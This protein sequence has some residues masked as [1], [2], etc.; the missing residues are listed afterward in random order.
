M[1]KRRA[2]S[3]KGVKGWRP[4]CVVLAAFLAVFGVALLA[5][6]LAGYSITDFLE[7]RGPDRAE[8]VKELDELPEVVEVYDNSDEEAETADS[9]DPQDGDASEISE[10]DAS[11]AGDGD[12]PV[13]TDAEGESSPEDATDVETQSEPDPEPDPEPQPQPDPEPEDEIIEFVDAILGV[14]A[15]AYNY[16]QIGSTAGRKSGPDPYVYIDPNACLMKVEVRTMPTAAFPGETAAE[17]LETFYQTRYVDQAR[18]DET[19]TVTQAPFDLDMHGEPAAR[20]E[21]ERVDDDRKLLVQLTAIRGA[22][23]SALVHGQIGEKCAQNPASVASLHKTTDAI[24]IQEPAPV[25]YVGYKPGSDPAEYAV[26]CDYEVINVKGPDA[27]A[28]QG[29]TEI[30]LGPA[31]WDVC[32]AFMRENDQEFWVE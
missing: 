2:D 30:E 14:S 6:L 17:G 18:S 32:A 9:D 4:G 7:G 24:V 13:E 16:Y 1:S 20:L 21:A 23:R 19:W 11:E 25:C 15:K 29:F 10:G 31:T 3:K 26:G 27:L 12:A 28:D 8:I 5:V 22:T